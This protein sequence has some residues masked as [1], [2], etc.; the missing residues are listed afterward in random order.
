MK[1]EGGTLLSSGPT[2]RAAI[3]KDG[4][5]KLKSLGGVYGHNPHTRNLP[6]KDGKLIKFF[7]LS[8]VW[9]HLIKKARQGHASLI[10]RPGK[11]GK[12][13]II[14][15]IMVVGWILKKGKSVS[16]IVPDPPD[17]LGH[18][19]S[20]STIYNPLIQF[21]TRGKLKAVILT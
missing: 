3:R 16:P 11:G 13:I 7:I 5:R 8:E 21:T 20:I 2:D 1:K 17:Q 9:T 19:F 14:F 15:Q 4:N 10:G 12:I 6:F 18:R